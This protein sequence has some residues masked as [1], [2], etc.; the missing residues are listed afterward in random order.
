[1]GL[2]WKK[3]SINRTFVLPHLRR[4]NVPGELVF[5]FIVFYYTVILP[6]QS[7]RL[8]L[9]EKVKDEIWICVNFSWLRFFVFIFRPCGCLKNTKVCGKLNPV[10]FL[11][12]QQ[13]YKILSDFQRVKLSIRPHSFNSGCK[14]KVFFPRWVPFGTI[15]LRPIGPYPYPSHL[16]L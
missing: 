9:L 2:F 7:D 10:Y 4:K 3:Y 1:M 13:R 12:S 14:M 15:G 16:N 5:L 6:G 8:T 11:I